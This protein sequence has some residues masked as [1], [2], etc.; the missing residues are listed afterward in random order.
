MEN[1]LINYIENSSGKGFFEFGTVKNFK[2]KEHIFSDFRSAGFIYYLIEGQIFTG[3][4]SDQGTLGQSFLLY[5]KDVFGKYQMDS[6]DENCFAIA[7]EDSRVLI[8][9]EEE[10]LEITKVDV[11]LYNELLNRMGE[12]INRLED[13][14][15]SCVKR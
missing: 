2:R 12:R 1:K 4:Y 15:L 13:Q 11:E 3:S 6:K 8:F 9:S 10:I 5:E 7:L 14:H